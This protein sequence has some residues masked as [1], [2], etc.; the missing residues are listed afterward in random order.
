MHQVFV[1]VSTVM[2][3]AKTRPADAEGDPSAPVLEE[4]YKRRRAHDK[5]RTEIEVEKHVT[6]Q[7]RDTNGRLKTSVTPATLPV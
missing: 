2:T 6:Q 4:E 7:G 1:C 3:W 5:F